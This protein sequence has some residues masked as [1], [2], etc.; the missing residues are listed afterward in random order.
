MNVTLHNVLQQQI[1]T[2]DS[3]FGLKNNDETFNRL[4]C[5]YWFPQKHKTP[6]GAR[7]I[8]VGKKCINKQLR[9]HVTLSFKLCYSQTDT[10]HKK[11][12]YFSGIKNF[13]VIQ[14]NSLRL[15]RINKIS[16]RKAAKQVS[17]FDFSTLY[18]KIP[19]DKLLDVL[20]KVVN[21]VFKGGIRDYIVINKQGC[22][23]W[24]SKKRGHHFVL[25]KSLLKEA[26]KFLL[27][28][29]FFT[30]GNIIMIQIIGIPMGSEPAQFFADLFLAHE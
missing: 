5:I 13:W 7:F 10:Y 30:I 29:C 25:T 11:T 28:N 12:Y 27:H 4:P 9:K 3:I 6:S 8:I 19:R 17:T 26:K 18:T 2:L 15:E 23:S 24:S 21:F 22:A 14:N 16:K 1:N 20:Y